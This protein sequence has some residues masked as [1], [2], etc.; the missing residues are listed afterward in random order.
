MIQVWKLWWERERGRAKQTISSVLNCHRALWET[1][2]ER[3]IEGA[4]REWK[5]RMV[6]REQ[7]RVSKMPSEKA[8]E[9]IRWERAREK[10]ASDANEN[11]GFWAVACLRMLRLRCGCVLESAKIRW[12]LSSNRLFTLNPRLSP[13]LRISLTFLFLIRDTDPEWQD[14]RISK[15]ISPNWCNKTP[16]NNPIQYR[17]L[18]YRRL[19]TAQVGGA[20]GEGMFFFRTKEY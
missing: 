3:E 19:P 1:A 2:S 16:Q 11:G 9:R 7:Y 18:M 12:P 15:S 14:G 4:V 5:R 8:D 17:H 10:R 6:H 20:L 13:F